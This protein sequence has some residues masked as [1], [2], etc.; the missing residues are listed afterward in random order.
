MALHH[1]QIQALLSGSTSPQEEQRPRLVLATLSLWSQEPDLVFFSAAKH[2][3]LCPQRPQ[4]KCFYSILV[5]MNAS[6]FL[7]FCLL[8]FTSL[9]KGK[10]TWSTLQADTSGGAPSARRHHTSVSFLSPDMTTQG[11]IIFGG[12]NK[13]QSFSDA[14]LLALGAPV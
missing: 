3:G 1:Q 4:M 5:R 11:V 7:S 13:H 10:M 9:N 8:I 2:Q 14:Y 12:D 6:L